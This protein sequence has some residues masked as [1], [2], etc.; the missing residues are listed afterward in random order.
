MLKWLDFVF[1]RS[2]YKTLYLNWI[3]VINQLLQNSRNTFL[4][5]ALKSRHNNGGRCNNLSQLTA[6]NVLVKSF[7]SLKETKLFWGKNCKVLNHILICKISIKWPTF[8]KPKRVWDILLHHVHGSKK[9]NFFSVIMKLTF[10]QMLL[11]DQ[12]ESQKWGVP[13]QCFPVSLFYHRI[14]C[15]E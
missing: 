5:L 4:L 3:K 9:A 1:Y 8:K 14:D 6:R 2:W 11:V 13:K 7:C 15:C 12:S 10:Y